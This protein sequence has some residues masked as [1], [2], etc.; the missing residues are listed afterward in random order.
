MRKSTRLL[1]FTFGFALNVTGLVMSSLLN[2]WAFFIIHVVCVVVLS[3]QIY[4][5]ATQ[6][7]KENNDAI[8]S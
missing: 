6:L 1:W 3:Q 2:W 4:E 8:S 7:D 5:L